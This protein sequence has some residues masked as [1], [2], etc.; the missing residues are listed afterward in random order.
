MIRTHYG[1]YCHAIDRPVFLALCLDLS[2]LALLTLLMPLLYSDETTLLLLPCYLSAELSASCGQSAYLGKG[3]RLGELFVL[4]EKQEGRRGLCWT[5]KMSLAQCRFCHWDEDAGRE[6][7]PVPGQ[8]PLKA[9]WSSPKDL[10]Y[11]VLS[12]FTVLGSPVVRDS[13][14]LGWLLWQVE[15]PLLMLAWMTD[16]CVRCCCA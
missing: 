3:G 14:A 16:G 6:V 11:T 12:S 7:L 5:W 1:N 13:N 2:S 4:R 9:K 15:C 8:F 10:M